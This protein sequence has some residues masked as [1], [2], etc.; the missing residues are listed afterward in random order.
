MTKAQIVIRYHMTSG[1]AT[2]KAASDPA[3]MA[4]MMADPL[5][6]HAATGA[7]FRIWWGE[8]LVGAI[9]VS[10][11]PGGDKDEPCAIAGL[12]KIKDR[13]K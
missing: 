1:E 11:A 8:R 2:T 7:R 6:G 10:G 12:D 3:L 9:A 13:L 4:Q 5:M